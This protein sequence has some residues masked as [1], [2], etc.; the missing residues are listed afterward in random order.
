MVYLGYLMI[1]GYCAILF[2]LFPA[3]RRTFDVLKLNPFL[4]PYWAKYAGIFWIVFVF[5]YSGITLNLN[6]SENTFLLV[7]I[8][9]GL[10]MIAFSREKNEDEFAV[11]I[12]MKAMYIS[13]ISLFI[14]TGIFASFEVMEPGSFSKNAFVFFLM[15]FDATLFVY[16]TYF[17]FTKYWFLFKKK[18]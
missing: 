4:L 10:T 14:L 17:Y 11:Q 16:L 2:R 15:M 9:F 6:P 8:H 13:I 7:G 3:G 1:V 12:R 5:I 18:E